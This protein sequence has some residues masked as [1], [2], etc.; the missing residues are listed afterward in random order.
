M[1]LFDRLTSSEVRFWVVVPLLAGSLGAAYILILGAPEPVLSAEGQR[2]VQW[3]LHAAEQR[4]GR[5]ITAASLFGSGAL[6][7]GLTK[8]FPYGNAG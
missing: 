8:L 7:A 2:T 6:C 3:F 1:R 4:F 5:L